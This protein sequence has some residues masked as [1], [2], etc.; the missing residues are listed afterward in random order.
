M[1]SWVSIH[2]ALAPTKF[3]QR[4]WLVLHHPPT[5]CSLE[6]LARLTQTELKITNA[7][8][9]LTALPQLG[10]LVMLRELTLSGC[11]ELLHLPESLGR[12]EVLQVLEIESCPALLALPESFGDL[13]AL[14]NLNINNCG[15]LTSL[16]NT[17][18]GLKKLEKITIH[19]CAAFASLPETTGELTAL[20]DLQIVFCGLTCLPDSVG[21]LTALR[22]LDLHGCGKLACLPETLDQLVNLKWIMVSL[23]NLSRQKISGLVQ[24]SCQRKNDIIIAKHCGNITMFAHNYLPSLLAMVLCMQRRHKRQPKLPNKILLLVRAVLRSLSVEI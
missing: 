23:T 11:G 21:E 16:P 7:S 18:R 5:V 24:N 14:D 9:G 3:V 2:T 8:P 13:A 20:A 17:L 12:L 10:Q 6:L 15:A 22:I 19:N 4:G 1:E